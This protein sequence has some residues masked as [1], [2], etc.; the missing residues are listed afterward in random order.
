MGVV[1]GELAHAQQA[2]QRAMRL[3][4]VAAAE[5]R[6]PDRQVAVAL[7]ALLE[8][9]H[10]GRAVHRLHRHHAGGAGDNGAVTLGVGNLVRDSKHIFRIFAPMAG[11]FPLVDVH[12]LRRLDLVIAGPVELAAHITFQLAPDEIALGMPEAGTLRLVLEVEQV[13]FLA[14]LAVVASSRLPTSRR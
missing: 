8:H 11:F 9:Q 2:V 1:L 14:E 12:Q 3:V 13:H 10:M 7:D 4:A 5:F 6:H